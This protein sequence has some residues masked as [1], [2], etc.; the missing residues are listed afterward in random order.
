VQSLLDAPV[1]RPSRRSSSTRRSWC[2]SG[3]AERSKLASTRSFSR[4]LQRSPFANAIHKL[5]PHLQ[6]AVRKRWME[7]RREL[8]KAVARPDSP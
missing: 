7:R 4:R 6:E 2:G 3:C 1:G 5:P 8:G